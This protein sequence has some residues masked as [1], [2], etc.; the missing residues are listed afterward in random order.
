MSNKEWGN[1]TWKLFHTLAAQIN[2][3]KFPEVRAKLINIVIRTCKNL[4]CP[5]CADHASNHVLKR[6]YINNIKTKAH[7]IE[8]LRQ[9][10]NIVNIKLQ[11]KTFTMNEIND[12]YTSVNLR[13]TIHEFIRLYSV[14]YHNMRLMVNNMHRRQ[15]LKDLIQELNIIKYAVV[16]TPSTPQAML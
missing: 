11:K 10:H 3:E 14:Q 6:C 15:F 7:F 1:I 12:M 16:E 8:F 13:S 4:P 5:F 9:L 2:E